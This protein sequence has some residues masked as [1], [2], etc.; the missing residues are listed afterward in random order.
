MVLNE[1]GMITYGGRNL[2]DFGVYIS[3]NGTFNAPERDVKMVAIPG[4]NG[5][6]TL[7]NGRFKNI[8]IKYPAFIVEDFGRNV[9][10]L[11]DFLGTIRGY[12]RLEDTYHPDEYR[13]ARIS[14][15]FTVK[16]EDKLRAGKFDLTFDCMPQRW[17]KSGEAIIDGAG[18]FGVAT[19]FDVL[20]PTEQDALPN[21]KLTMDSNC[22][23]TVFNI[24]DVQLTIN[25]P[26]VLQPIMIDCAMQNVYGETDQANLNSYLVLDDG[27]FPVL[28]P[29]VNTISFTPY[30]QE[31]YWIGGCTVDIYPRWWCL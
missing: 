1:R 23:K 19:S 15:A 17:L 22:T 5:D 11:R 24:N 27:T 13:M 2:A 26:S 8:K 16:P 31:G 6:L 10:A 7:D 4:R 12:S 18:S 25:A 28:K 9:D 14:G 30:P 3:G 29:G 20:N 21:I